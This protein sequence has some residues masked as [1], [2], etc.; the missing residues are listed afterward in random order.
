MAR[1]SRISGGGNSNDLATEMRS[2]A[3]QARSAPG[4]AGAGESAIAFC[5][6]HVAW[7]K[8][9]VLKNGKWVRACP[10]CSHSPPTVSAMKSRWAEFYPDRWTTCRLT[11]KLLARLSV[12]T[13]RIMQQCFDTNGEDGQAALDASLVDIILKSTNCTLHDLESVTCGKISELA[14]TT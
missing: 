14:A 11:G 13:R 5:S 8:V 10:V 4:D 7:K 2:N 9:R 3:F 12:E 1:R 6:K